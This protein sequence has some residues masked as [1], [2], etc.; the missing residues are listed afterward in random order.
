MH[1]LSLLDLIID[2]ICIK[3]W[4]DYPYQAPTEYPPL[5]NPS[6][7]FISN[8]PWRKTLFRPDLSKR[9]SLP[10][11]SERV[12]LRP[13]AKYSMCCHPER[14]AIRTGTGRM[15]TLAVWLVWPVKLVCFLFSPFS[16]F[17]IILVFL[18]QTSSSIVFF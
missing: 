17:T 6:E 15:K 2:F 12:F 18:S 3:P 11:S 7:K 5:L 9:L 13:I 16:R 8:R 1:V 10:S 4:Q 14:K